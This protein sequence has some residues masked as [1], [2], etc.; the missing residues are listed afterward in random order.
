MYH[1]SK[2]VILPK[3]LTNHQV[4]RA[5][6]ILFLLIGLVGS[7]YFISERQKSLQQQSIVA[8]SQIKQLEEDKEYM[9]TYFQ[10]YENILDEFKQVLFRERDIPLF[11]NGISDIS[12]ENNV[13]V[14]SIRNLPEKKITINKKQSTSKK[15]KQATFQEDDMSLTIAITP[16]RV[17]VKGALD[18]ILSLLDALEQS[19]QLLVISDFTF[20][21][22]CPEMA[23]SFQI[24]LY[25]LG[26]N[27]TDE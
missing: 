13:T 26:E 12:Q 16:L 10:R 21:R 4:A 5:M 15:L 19:K 17:Q 22:K 25:G 23:S 9:D 18:N 27:N 24:N 20:R 2:I 8:S 6:L 14:A 1:E 11:L 7:Y 3:P